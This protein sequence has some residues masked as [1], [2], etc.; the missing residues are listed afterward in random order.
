MPRGWGQNHRMN[1]IAGDKGIVKCPVEDIDELV[2]GVSSR[3]SS[4]GF[5]RK[6]A[7]S[8]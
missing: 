7:N 3:N 1:I 4:D 6:P 2:F 8:F 5:E